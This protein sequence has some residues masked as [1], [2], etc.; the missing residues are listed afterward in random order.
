VIFSVIYMVFNVTMVMC[1]AIN[2]WH[3]VSNGT[4]NEIYSV[5]TWDKVVARQ[6]YRIFDLVWTK[7]FIVETLD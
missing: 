2:L 3:I 7:V 5:P 1:P 4:L 6:L